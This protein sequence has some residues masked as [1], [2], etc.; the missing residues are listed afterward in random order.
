MSYNKTNKAGRGVCW[1]LFLCYIGA[2]AY[3]LFFA[4][5]YGRSDDGN[6]RYNLVLFQEITRCIKY[7][8]I[9]GNEVVL[10][11][12]V[13]NVVGFMPF[14]FLLPLLSV[15]ERR[16]VMVLLLTFELSLVVEVVQ[17]FTGVGSFDVD[18]LLLNTLGGIL[19]YGCYGMFARLSRSK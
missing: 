10:M 14:G 8:A 6:F 11:N 16:L 2:L 7:R 3:F 9:L 19:G 15:K 5:D 4:E 17:L 1:V 12:L 13:G 18:D